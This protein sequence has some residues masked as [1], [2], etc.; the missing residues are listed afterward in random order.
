MTKM[1]RKCR[2]GSMAETTSTQDLSVRGTALR[3]AGLRHWECQNCHAQIETP[4]QID[5]NSSLIHAE[6][7]RRREESRRE[8]GL[9]RGEEIKTLRKRFSLTQSLAAQLFGGGPVAFSKYESEDTAQSAPMNRLLQISLIDNPE[10]IAHLAARYGIALS[11]ETQRAIQA[12]I[13]DRMVRRRYGIIAYEALD[14]ASLSFPSEFPVLLSEAAN[15]ALYTR[16]EAPQR[17]AKAS[18]EDVLAMVA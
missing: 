12:C 1:C 11:D 9:L 3:V 6:L 8:S 16:Y 7:K 2:A 10:N 17:P 15:E 13:L 5:F 18:P 14:D 4:D